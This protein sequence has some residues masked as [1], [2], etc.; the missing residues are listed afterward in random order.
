M[1]RGEEPS[2]EVERPDA[3]ADAALSRFLAAEA[4]P[5]VVRAHQVTAL[6]LASDG[7]RWLPRC[8][9]ALRSQDR[10]A[11]RLIGIDAG[12]TDGSGALLSAV[13]P[14]TLAVPPPP[15]GPVGGMAAALAQGVVAA[16]TPREGGVP[17]RQD[18][19]ESAA[20][21]V[22][23][24]A[25]D[26]SLSWYW[27]IHDD[28]APDPRCLEA[29]LRGA[30]RFPRAAVL[31][32]KA[33]SW[34]DPTRLV[35][36]GN[37]WSPGKP[38]V[39]PL[40]VAERDQGQYDID[41]PVYAGD[42]A[43][44]LVRADVWDSLDG[45]DPELGN[46]AGPADLCRRCWGSGF[47][48]VF[49]PSA[50]VA[51]RRAG[52]RGV[53]REGEHPRAAQR[54]GQLQLE[55]SQSPGWALAWRY[56]RAWLVTA[57]R[58]LALLLTKE[59]EEA[60]SEMSGA[61]RILGHPQ[62]I[63]RARERARREPVTS[64]RRPAEVRARRGVALTHSLD[65]WSVTSHGS[66]VSRWWPLPHHV[67]YP[68][69]V[70]GVLA[71]VALVRDPAQ[72]L[73]SGQL[74]GGGLLP[75]PGAMDLL[76]GSLDSWHDARF[77]AGGPMPVYL[78]L[79]AAASVPALGSVDLV[80]RGAFGFALPLAFLSCYVALGSSLR[81]PQRMLAAL[82]YAALPAGV[83][84]SGGGR[85]STLGL[86]LL[87]PPTARLVWRALSA[88]RA[89]SGQGRARSTLAA[90]TMLGI[91]VAFAPSVF[92][93]A[94]L[95]AAAA[96]VAA[97]LPRWAMRTGA[98]ILGIAGFFLV[99]WVPRVATA[100]WLALGE[101]GV[102]DPSLGSPGPT[103]WGLDPGGPTSVA[104]AGVPLLVLAAV[105]VWRASFGQ[106]WLALLVAAVGLVGA[107]AWVQPIVERVWPDVG[108]A[109]V[110]PGA[111]L[112]LAGGILNVVVSHVLADQRMAARSLSVAWVA[113][114]AT[115]MAGWWVA[116]R[117][118][119]VGSGEGIPAVA[120]LDAQSSA[121][122]RSLVLARTDGGV[123][124]AVAAGPATR[125]GDADALAGEPVDPGFADA[126]AGLV[127]G[128]SG[129]V[130]RELGG[131]AVRFVVFNGSPEDPVVSSLDATVGLRQLARAP[132][133]SLWL[134]IGDPTRAWLSGTTTT[135]DVEV[136]AAIEVPVLTSPTSVDVVLHPQAELPRR[137]VVAERVDPG[138]R[139]AASGVDLALAPDEQGMLTATV[140][141]PG[142]LQ[143][144]HGSAWPALA[145]AQLLGVA[146][147]VVLSLPKQ[148]PRD[149]DAGPD[150]GVSP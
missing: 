37:R 49:L 92:V 35:G 111:W 126:V 81:V 149:P 25:P 117:D 109:V 103:V 20:G 32:P 100:P 89:G 129:A 74:R 26:E 96:W 107:A 114:V 95:T 69:A 42:S 140:T 44:M 115:L 29:L 51:H 128:A 94:L 34:S 113:V 58:G 145:I 102:N 86:L 59:P 38:I 77:G 110:W 144:V 147:L 40:D 127:S 11:D 101:V 15:D 133:Q 27:L 50:V 33:V 6:V 125:L 7:A 91:V 79:L 16:A 56:L 2:A 138:W 150:S 36:V 143:V 63:R 12:S 105:A 72:I 23:P 43:G 68:L 60:A 61:W 76:R 39:D 85:L 131:R 31:V 146:G 67:W 48:V 14:T 99:L 24:G 47:E 88:A 45:M 28:C 98:G 1:T 108:G 121:R 112:L 130:Q 64:L 120:S 87:A 62:R 132:E 136:A 71:L 104:W 70:A 122:P 54:A 134:V 82:G 135:A 18:A 21:P 148:H 5:E 141:L 46:W 90:G 55:L 10:P 22:D 4:G 116:P 30:D 118:I 123:R 83:A 41:R 17:S 137:L 78:P 80:L 142:P 65:V 124:F 66:L 3:R 75:A 8:L 9:E 53:R 93:A 19:R 106:R 13:I 119:S 52:N 84:A 73:G 57:M 97:G 139:G